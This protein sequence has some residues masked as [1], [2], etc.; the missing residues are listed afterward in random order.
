MLH[1][2]ACAFKCTESRNA[3]Y[4]TSPN[5]TVNERKL[6]NAFRLDKLFFRHR[7]FP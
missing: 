7:K 5:F 6:N 4:S 1:F 3:F 2:I